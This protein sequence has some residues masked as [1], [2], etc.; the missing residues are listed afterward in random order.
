MSFALPGIVVTDAMA[1][2]IAIYKQL[3]ATLVRAGGALL[4]EQASVEGGPPWD[5]FQA[6]TPEGD[7]ALV[8]A[9]QGQPDSGDMRVA[10]TG[11]DPDSSYAVESVDAGQLGAATGADLMIVGVEIFQ[12]PSTVAHVLMLRRVEPTSESRAEAR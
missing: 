4:S 9:F 7:S 10:L 1:R 12:S 5:V 6:T 3:R 11:L 8:F 2:E